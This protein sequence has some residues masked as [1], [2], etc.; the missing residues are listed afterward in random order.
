MLPGFAG[1]M[2]PADGGGPNFAYQGAVIHTG[3]LGEKTQIAT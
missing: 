2:E 3:S 1:I